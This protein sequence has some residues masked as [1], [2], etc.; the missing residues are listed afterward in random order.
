MIQFV[1]RDLFGVQDESG[2]FL[3]EEFPWIVRNEQGEDG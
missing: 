3:G 2:V 1:P